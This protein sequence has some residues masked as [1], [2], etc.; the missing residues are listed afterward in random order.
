[1]QRKF[2]FKRADNVTTS[3]TSSSSPAV[4]NN[5]HNSIKSTTTT[6][7]ATSFTI[8][9][10]PIFSNNESPLP[11]IKPNNPNNNSS[12]NIPFSIQNRREAVSSASVV[13]SL[14]FN[15]PSSNQKWTNQPGN[16]KSKTTNQPTSSSDFKYIPV[17]TSAKKQD[18]E[19]KINDFF[20]QKNDEYI[21]PII[22]DETDQDWKNFGKV[23]NKYKSPVKPVSTESPPSDY[24][25]FQK[26]VATV[27][28]Q[29]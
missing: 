16:L 10:K 12:S 22:E 25:V 13:K 21:P 20:K 6:T 9:K 14:P 8:A 4:Y 28:P 2:V 11:S 3:T 17:N 24:K 29:M 18:K 5:N 15:S 1:M 26:P 19:R 7:T 23:Q 27:T